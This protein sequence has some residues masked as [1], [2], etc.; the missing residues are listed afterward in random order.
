MTII[1][2]A[3]SAQYA[4]RMRN[5]RRRK[6]VRTRT[7]RSPSTSSN[8]TTQGRN[9]RSPDSVK[10]TVTA[11]APPENSHATGFCFRVSPVSAATCSTR[12]PNAAIARTPSSAS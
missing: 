2:Y 5:A 6:Y 7:V 10:K 11:I 12:T 4:G 1:T 3:T 8:R 9:S